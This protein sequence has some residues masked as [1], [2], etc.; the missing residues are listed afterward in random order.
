MF[1]ISTALISRQKYIS[2]VRYNESEIIWFKILSNSSLMAR[3][4]HVHTPRFVNIK[5][6]E[7]QYQTQRA[8]LHDFASYIIIHSRQSIVWYYIQRF[9]EA[10]MMA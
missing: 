3:E 7:I 9:R 6:G 10:F 4:R 1:K 8:L 2:V 5:M